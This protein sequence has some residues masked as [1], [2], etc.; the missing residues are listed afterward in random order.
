MK[1]QS[2]IE[3]TRITVSENQSYDDL[4]V[5]KYLCRVDGMKFKG[6]GRQSEYMTL[7]AE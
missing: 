1:L 4:R 2:I 5:A 3:A 6:Y 7:L